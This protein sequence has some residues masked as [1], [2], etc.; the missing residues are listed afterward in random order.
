MTYDHA[1]QHYIF[2][3]NVCDKEFCMPDT[4]AWID[5]WKTAINEGWRS[6]K[7]KGEWIHLCPQ[8]EVENDPIR[9]S[10]VR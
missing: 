3:C 10:I 9:I 5:S 6:K 1:K 4:Y 2:A 7:F 8:C